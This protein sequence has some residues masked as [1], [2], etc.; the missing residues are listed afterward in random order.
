VIDLGCGAAH[1]SAWLARRGPRP[2]GIDNSQAQLETAKH[3]QVEDLTEIRPPDGSG[4][5]YPSVTLEWAQ[6]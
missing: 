5:R 1:M 2:V 6:R 4:T 3:L